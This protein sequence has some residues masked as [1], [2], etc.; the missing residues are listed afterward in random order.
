MRGPLIAAIALAFLYHLIALDRR[1]AAMVA[2]RRSAYQSSAT[3][4]A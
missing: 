3:D 1:S 4:T 2:K